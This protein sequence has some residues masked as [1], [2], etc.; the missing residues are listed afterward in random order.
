MLLLLKLLILKLLILLVLLLLILWWLLLLILWWLLLLILWWSLLLMLLLLLLLLILMLL[1][2]RKQVVTPVLTDVCLHILLRVHFLLLEYLRSFRVVG[3][4]LM[5]RFRE[6]T[7][8]VGCVRGIGVFPFLAHT[9]LVFII[10]ASVHPRHGVVE[11]RLEEL[12]RIK[13][14]ESMMTSIVRSIS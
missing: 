10:Q 7:G 2:D 3:V 12:V 4:L 5:A 8:A 11:R 6:L 1:S 13:V 14:G 9:E